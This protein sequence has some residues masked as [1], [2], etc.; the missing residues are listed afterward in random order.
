MCVNNVLCLLVVMQYTT[1]QLRWTLWW[2]KKPK[3]AHAWLWWLLLLLLLLWITTIVGQYN[4]QS[5]KILSFTLSLSL[6]FFLSQSVL[7][8][9]AYVYLLPSHSRDNR[10]YSC[11]QYQTS[12]PHTLTQNYNELLP[13]ESFAAWSETKLCGCRIYIYI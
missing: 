9:W 8:V 4:W 2:Q 3:M 10:Q 5:V 1:T 7:F 11:T 12:I 6:S 13:P